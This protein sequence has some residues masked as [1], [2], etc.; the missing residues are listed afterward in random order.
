MP[1]A[2]AALPPADLSTLSQL[3]DEALALAPPAV[4]AWLAALPAAH[5]HLLPLL[6]DMLDEHRAGQ[7]QALPAPDA[8]EA[9]AITELCDAAHL[10]LSTRL[11]LFCQVLAAIGH[12]PAQMDDA[13][14][15]TVADVYA[16]GVMLYELLVGSLPQA[17]HRLDLLPP[18]R[19][20]MPP[21][22]AT[23]RGLPH[24]SWLR[25]LLAGELDAIVLKAL[26]HSPAEG[27]GSVEHLAED[28]RRFLAKD[29]QPAY[30]SAA[31]KWQVLPVSTNR[32]HTRW[33]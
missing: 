8:L 6:Q 1:I 30:Q 9:A 27:Y 13:A 18:S 17:P 26:R 5:R 19:A 24:L 20:E 3:L 22:A 23:R 25:A 10:D 31:K 21:D 15:S 7:C 29:P 11:R 12:A 33:A 32:C 4:D 28:I 16:L 2:L 14:S